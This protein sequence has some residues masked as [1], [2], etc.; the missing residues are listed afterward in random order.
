MD[1][2]IRIPDEYL[3]DWDN[4]DIRIHRFEGKTDLVTICDASDAFA[5]TCLDFKVLTKGHGELIDKQRL[6]KNPDNYCYF[7]DR[8]INAPIEIDAERRKHK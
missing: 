6:L 5:G 1:I 8:I 7:Y 2:M 3:N 4:I